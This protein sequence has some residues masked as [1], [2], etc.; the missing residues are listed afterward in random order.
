MYKFI[1]T[2]LASLIINL[3]KAQEKIFKTK[4]DDAIPVLNMGTFHMGYTSDA[5]KTEFDKHSTE[6]V[7]QVHE[8]AKMLAKFKPTIIVVETTPKY[9]DIIRKNYLAYL[10]TPKVKFESPMK[11]NF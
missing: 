2:A 5:H 8:I 3:A 4:F 9:Q 1:I 11:L 10:K 6:N 7:R